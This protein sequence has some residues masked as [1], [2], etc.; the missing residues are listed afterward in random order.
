MSIY[1][2]LR[3]SLIMVLSD[4]SRG[5][6][7]IQLVRQHDQ[8][9]RLVDALGT[10][11]MDAVDTWIHTYIHTYINGYIVF[12]IRCSQVVSP[13]RTGDSYI[14]CWLLVAE[15]FTPIGHYGSEPSE[16]ITR[17]TSVLFTRW[18]AWLLKSVKCVWHSVVCPLSKRQIWLSLTDNK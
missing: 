9:A 18:F 8:I 10:M 17:V 2:N 15:W 14:T 7:R 13:D 11:W 5:A 16:L 12:L 4:S 6:I 1:Y 3:C